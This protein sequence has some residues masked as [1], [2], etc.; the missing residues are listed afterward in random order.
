MKISQE[1][2]RLKKS[3]K[4]LK[5]K[6][7][8]IKSSNIINRIKMAKLKIWKKGKLSQEGITLTTNPK[9]SVELS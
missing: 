9:Y 3:A 6:I 8:K 4:I 5:L 7:K 2:R 1:S